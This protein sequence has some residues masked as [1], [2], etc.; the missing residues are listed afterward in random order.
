M[1]HQMTI[2]LTDAEYAALAVEAAKN[3]KPVESLLHEVLI[4]HI[5]PTSRPARLLSNRQVQEYLVSEGIIEQV[6]SGEPE[7]LEEQTER[8]RLAHLFGQGKPVSEMIIEDRG[9]Y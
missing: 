5:R 7:A 8:E 4:Q 3:G 2:T 9:P 1:A 6:P